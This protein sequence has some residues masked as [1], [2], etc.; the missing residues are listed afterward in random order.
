MNVVEFCFLK[1]YLDVDQFQF[2]I[3][4]IRYLTLKLLSI[5]NSNQ[6]GRPVGLYGNAL[7]CVHRY[8]IGFYKLALKKSL[9]ADAS[10]IDMQQIK[11]RQV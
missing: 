2:L 1:K 11:K 4:S 7:N 8:M 5:T 10:P 9:D 3:H 6:E